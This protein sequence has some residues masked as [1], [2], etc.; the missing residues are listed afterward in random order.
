MLLNLMTKNDLQKT[1][2]LNI[3]L[4]MGASIEKYVNMNGYLIVP[5]PFSTGGLVKNAVLLSVK[6]LEKLDANIYMKIGLIVKRTQRSK[7]DERK[8]TYEIRCNC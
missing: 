4:L 1:L 7:R 6:H 5:I 3:A 2:G 8:Y